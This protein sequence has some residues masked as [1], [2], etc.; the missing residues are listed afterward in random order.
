MLRS[1]Y[2]LR[3]AGLFESSMSIAVKKQLY[4]S[5]CRPA[6]MYGIETVVLN[7]S[8]LAKL[9]E[10]T[11]TVAIKDALGISRRTYNA[12]LWDSMK[13]SLTEAQ[14][15]SRKL[16]FI[17]RL[18]KNNYTSTI[19][20]IIVAKMSWASTANNKWEKKSILTELWDATKEIPYV[21][22]RQESTAKQLQNKFG[23]AFPAAPPRPDTPELTELV[24]HAHEG[25]KKMQQKKLKQIE[26]LIRVEF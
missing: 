24:K 16:G 12:E 4:Q 23:I 25:D 13:L 22:N 15:N 11:E 17:S 6:L 19:M 5:Y 2:G 1:F 3:P 7:K 26:H 10:T 18:A 14:V 8:E 20:N 21:P 9:T